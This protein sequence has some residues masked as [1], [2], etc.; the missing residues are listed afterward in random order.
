MTASTLHGSVAAITP[1]DEK[2]IA[3]ELTPPLAWPTLLLAALL[4]SA[5]WTLIVLGLLRT[6]PLWVCAVALTPI[7]YAHYTLVHESIHGNLAPGHPKLRWL[8]TLVGWLGA[9]GLS[10]NWPMLMRSHVLHHA[11]TN[12]EADPD[13]WVK[14]SFGH[15]LAKYF[16]VSIVMTLIPFFVLRYIMPGQ[17]RRMTAHLRGSEV[18]QAS[19]VASMVIVLLGVSVY[20]GRA[21]DWLFLLLIPTRLAALILNIFFSWLPHYPFDRTERYRNTRISLWPGGTFLTLQQNLHL[22]HHLWPSVPFYNY[23]RLYRRLLPVLIA[24][25]S[26]IEGFAPR[27]LDVRATH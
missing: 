27:G 25:G 24:K 5:F 11:H 15:L 23:A 10:Y 2:R 12:S 18:V 7:S 14:G 22:M 26:R 21:W 1:A 3:R 9:L 4:P 17:Y 13:I 6:L 16:V 20:F 19:A 8:N